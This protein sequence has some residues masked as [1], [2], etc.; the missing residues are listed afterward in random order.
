MTIPIIFNREPYDDADV[1]W[2]SLGLAGGL[3]EV[4]RQAGV[5]RK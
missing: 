4:E 2:D 3:P 5:F 1:A